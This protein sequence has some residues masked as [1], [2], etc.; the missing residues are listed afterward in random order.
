MPIQGI[1]VNFNALKRR[2]DGKKDRQTMGHAVPQGRKN[3]SEFK[4]EV[5]VKIVFGRI[6]VPYV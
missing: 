5:V 3:L 4:V 6:N 1:F 2:T